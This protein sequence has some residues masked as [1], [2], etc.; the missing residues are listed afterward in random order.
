M[1]TRN[2]YLQIAAGLLGLLLPLCVSADPD[3]KAFAALPAAETPKELQGIG[4]KEHLG[5]QIDPNLEFTDDQGRKVRIGDYF[6]NGTK[7]VLLSIVYYSCPNLCNYHLNGLTAALKQ[8]PWTI[9]DQ[10]D[11]VAVSMDHKETPEV[12]SKKKDNYIAEYGR[13]HSAKGWHF[14]VGSEENVKKLTDSIGFG[15]RWDEKEQQY[16]HAAAATVMTPDQKISRYL[17]GIEFD[18]KT[19]RMSLLEASSGKIGSVVDQIILFCFHYDPTKNKYT[20]Y[21]YNVM[22][23]AGS[24]M[25]LAL[26]LILVPTWLR[27][28]RRQ[29]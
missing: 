8:M 4:I 24:I 27:E 7:P 11:L 10:F 15:F 25:L 6:Q 13:P 20:L 9:G 14:L 19:V 2:T 17:Y 5:E 22:R 29:S 1:K 12:A 28:R 23:I 26:A 21:A 18:P 3:P 16:A